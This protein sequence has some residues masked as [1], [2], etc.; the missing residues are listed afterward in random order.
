[1]VQTELR[2]FEQMSIIEKALL[3][4][5]FIVSVMNL[6]YIFM[7]IHWLSTGTA[8]SAQ[9]S[10]QIFSNLLFALML[11]GVLIACVFEWRII[12]SLEEVKDILRG[13]KKK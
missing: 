2:S 10:G 8:V 12:E 13:K 3:A 6:L 4:V 9:F 11:Q 1:M 7:A 5:V